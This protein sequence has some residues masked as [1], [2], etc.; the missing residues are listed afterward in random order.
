VYVKDGGDFEYLSRELLWLTEPPGRHYLSILLSRQ[1][2][3]LLL[4]PHGILSHFCF[5]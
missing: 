2:K 5:N 1:M 3:A 4:I